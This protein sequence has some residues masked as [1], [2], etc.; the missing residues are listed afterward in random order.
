MVVLMMRILTQRRRLALALL[1]LSS[2]TIALHGQPRRVIRVSAERF[3]FTPSEIVVERG[4]EVELRLSSEDTAHG[5]R[6]L[7]T[8]TNVQIPK[9]GQKELSVTFRAAEAG[10]Y[11]F[12]CSRMC[13]AGH[14]FMRGVLIVREA[15]AAHR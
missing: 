2:S 5:F 10:R 14:H 4:E 7:G 1:W 12:E 9:R 6:I 13:G 8:A 15:G 3:V 11:T